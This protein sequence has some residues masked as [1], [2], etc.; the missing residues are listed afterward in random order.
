MF[1]SIL[2][3]LLIWF[4]GFIK[5]YFMF[6]N[7]LPACMYVYLV[8]AWWST[9]DVTICIKTIIC[10]FNVLNMVMIFFL[11]VQILLGS[12]SLKCVLSQ[13]LASVYLFSTLWMTPLCVVSCVGGQP[14]L[15]T[16][17]LEKL[18]TR[19]DHKDHFHILSFS[20]DGCARLNTCEL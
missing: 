11:I 3:F 17:F 2:C 1:V 18:R 4:E 9:G 10:L 5:F 7:V 16:S 20:G 19:M 6:M 8:R 13:N 15:G 14:L 12:S